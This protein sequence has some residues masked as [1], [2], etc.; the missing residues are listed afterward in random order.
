MAYTDAQRRYNSSEAGKAA[1]KKY[2]LKKKALRNET[3][4]AE[5]EAKAKK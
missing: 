1:H 2:Q 4:K 3:K 5:A